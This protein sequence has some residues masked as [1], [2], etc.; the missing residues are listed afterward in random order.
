MGEILEVRGWANKHPYLF[1]CYN[2]HEL[3]RTERA[4]HKV[5]SKGNLRAY[6]RFEFV[7]STHKAGAG[8]GGG[9][10]YSRCL[11]ITSVQIIAWS[12]NSAE[13]EVTLESQTKI[14][15]WILKDKNCTV[16]SVSVHHGGKQ[17]LNLGAEKLVKQ[18]IN[19]FQ[20]NKNRIQSHY[21]V[22]FSTKNYRTCKETRNCDQK[23]K[24]TRFWFQMGQD[25]GFRGQT[26]KQTLQLCSRS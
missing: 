9:F 19:N 13:T 3:G 17:L 8:E 5:N 23:K 11:N 10:T 21:N 7:P 22:N 20:E 16:I 1:D 12:L 18:K 4:K 6:C 25:V 26:S 14:K 2:M 24:V 15:K